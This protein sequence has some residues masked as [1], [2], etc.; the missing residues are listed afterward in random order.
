M[1]SLVTCGALSRSF[2]ACANPLD[3]SLSLTLLSEVGTVLTS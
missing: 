2:V 3:L 1:L